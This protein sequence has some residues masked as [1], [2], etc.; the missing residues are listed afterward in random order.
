MRTK[1]DIYVFI[2]ALLLDFT[3]EKREKRKDHLSSLLEL[4]YWFV[5]CT[6]IC[7][8]PPILALYIVS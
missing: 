3:K 2:V 7:V 1:L 8:Y 4:F 5:V 6:W